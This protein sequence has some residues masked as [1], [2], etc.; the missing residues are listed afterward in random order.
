MFLKP[1]LLQLAMNNDVSGM[2][3]SRFLIRLSI[4]KHTQAAAQ[5]IKASFS[6]TSK[7]VVHW[8]GKILPD[9]NQEKVDRLSV[10]V[11]QQSF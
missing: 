1:L 7:L 4:Q 3:V 9:K 2:A 10:L 6:L 11:L 5:T 8:D